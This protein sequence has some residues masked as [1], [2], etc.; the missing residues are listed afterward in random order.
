MSS[1]P[2]HQGT[3]PPENEKFAEVGKAAALAAGRL[4][5]E[6]LRTDF[7]VSH[8]GDTNL[9]T[10]VD[11]AAEKLIVSRILEAFPEHAILA[12]ENHDHTVRSGCTWIIDPL[13]GTTNY[14]H[15]YPVFAVSVGLEI[16]GELEWGIVYNPNL[17]E[18]FTARRGGGAFCNGAPI[19]VSNTP[20]LGSSLLATGFPYDIRTSKAN[21]N[22]FAN[23]MLRA[24]AVRRGGSAALD[25]CYVAA[26]RFD[27]FWELALHPW[28]C[29]AGF[30]IVR[31]AGGVVTDFDGAPGSIDYPEVVASNG[32]IH[33]QVL[34]VL[35]SAGT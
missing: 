10:E 8:K 18:V 20:D 9:V 13:D 25:F 32:L 28:D 23:F 24:Q 35:R 30:L 33:E 5:M 14:A 16:E 6:K 19:H 27:G 29:A 21:L 1:P 17:E 11:I 26:G 7:A 4:L 3:R 15:R 22:H 2:R 31:E 12:E 34:E